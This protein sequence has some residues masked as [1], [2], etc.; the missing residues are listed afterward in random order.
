[1]ELGAQEWRDALF[2]RYVLDPPDLPHY[3]DGCKST[4]SICHA[5][6]CK[7]FSLVTARHNELCDGVAD[8]AGISFTPFHVR[9]DPLIFAGCAVKRPKANPSRSKATTS[10][11]TTP[12]LKV[13]EQKGDLLIC[14]LWKN[15]TD[16]IHNMRV[17]KTDSKSHSA[18]TPGK[19]LQ[20]V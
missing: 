3:C 2:L 6:V 20:E 9:D 16:S 15:G 17:V 14:E 19:G 7:R 13:T 18:K 11:A 4:F 12:P 8:L 5:L 10:T 1:M